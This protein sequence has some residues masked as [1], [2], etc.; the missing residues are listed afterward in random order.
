MALAPEHT[1][2]VAID[3]QTNQKPLGYTSN[4]YTVLKTYDRPTP[5]YYT[6]GLTFAGPNVLLESAGLYGES[7]IHLLNLDDLSVRNQHKLDS[8]YFGEGTDYV[9]NEQGEREIYQLT[10]LERDVMVYNADT[11]ERKTMLQ[12]PSPIRE[13]WGLARRYDDEN[14]HKVQNLYITDGSANVYVCE[15]KTLAVKRT[16]NVK[17]GNGKPVNMLNELEFVKG[18]LWANIYT[19]NN[20]AVIDV[21]SGNVD[22][23]MDFTS[24]VETAKGKFVADRWNRGY[25]LNGI[26]YNPESDRLILTGKKWSQLYEIQVQDD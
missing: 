17:D 16:I 2:K 13:G 20:I 26:A 7:A 19:T 15:P 8:K 24:L 10:W 21:N 12:L 11:L 3:L 18:K 4:S 14:G 1:Q 5:H 25:C 23:F 22:K 9:L 6:Q